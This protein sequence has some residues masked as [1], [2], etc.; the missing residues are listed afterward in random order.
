MNML[1]ST[2]TDSN[3][4]EKM[5]KMTVASFVPGGTER[6]LLDLSHSGHIPSYIPFNKVD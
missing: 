6:V 1:F 5:D 3:G 2:M 4:A